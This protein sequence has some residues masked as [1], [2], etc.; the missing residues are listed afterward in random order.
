MT[1]SNLYDNLNKLNSDELVERYKSGYYTDEA[2]DVVV[3]IFNERNISIPLVDEN[4]S[5]VKIPFY[6]SHPIWFWTFF[7]AGVTI[8][9]RLIQ[10]I[11][12][13]F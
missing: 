1:Q 10:K 4:Y 13:S 11:A 8:L 6:K 3:S 12:N 9:I 7:G 5:S 2:K